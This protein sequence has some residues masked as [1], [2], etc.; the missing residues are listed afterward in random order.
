MK[1]P[2]LIK[3][4]G[5]FALFIF[6]YGCTE[7][8]YYTIVEPNQNLGKVNVYIED[9]ISTADA[10]AKLNREVG[11]QTEN[12]YIRNTTQVTEL[13]IKLVGDI[14]DVSIQSNSNLEKVTIEGTNSL[15]NRLD[16]HDFSLNFLVIKGIKKTKNL[17]MRLF[18]T[19][20]N[21]QID[22]YDL[23]IIDEQLKFG[24]RGI[25]NIANFHHLKYIDYIS[26]FQQG[27]VSGILGNYASLTL[28][29]LEECRNNLHLEVKTQQLTLPKLKK[30]RF[31]SLYYWVMSDIPYGAIIGPESFITPLLTDCNFE[32]RLK[33]NDFTTIPDLSFIQNLTH[34]SYLGLFYTRLNNAQVNNILQKC[35]SFQPI[36]GKTINLAE[37]NEMPTG[38][39]LIDK[40]T[41]IDQGNIVLTQ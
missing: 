7:E 27:N 1:S 24:V 23:E 40:Q 36:S 29:N 28:P 2:Q 4:F 16:V 34:C 35:L 9:N 12:I 3:T 18:S 22:I 30:I 13:N 31:L 21:K 32:I 19:A 38:Q 15:A 20:N 26:N 37:G 39:G 41:L 17:D 8:N 5:F 6:F 33:T 11:T 25:D 14:R 10:Q